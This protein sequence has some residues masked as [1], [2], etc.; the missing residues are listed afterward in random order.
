MIFSF[1]TSKGS[2]GFDLHATIKGLS[3]LLSD[4]SNLYHIVFN[5]IIGLKVRFI[6]LEAISYLTTIED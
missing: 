2:A 6:A 3:G 1:L 5:I 4:K